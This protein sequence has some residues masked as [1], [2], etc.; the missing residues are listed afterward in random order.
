MKYTTPEEVARLTSA[1]RAVRVKA[2]FAKIAFIADVHKD[3]KVERDR[4]HKPLADELW[5]ISKYQFD[6]KELNHFI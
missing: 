3:D 1:D 2:L 4:L 6:E 5:Q